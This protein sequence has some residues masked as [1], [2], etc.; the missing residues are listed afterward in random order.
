MTAAGID[1][2]KAALDVTIGTKL[3]ADNRTRARLL[4]GPY[5]V[6]PGQ[7]DLRPSEALFQACSA[8]D[9]C[10]VSGLTPAWHAPD[11]WAEQTYRLRPCSRYG[12]RR[13]RR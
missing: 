1:V 10:V 4:A 7:G 8:A 5:N 3:A 9:M 2:G 6:G 13:C 11:A 12:W